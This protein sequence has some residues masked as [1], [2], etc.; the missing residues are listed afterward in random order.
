MRPIK[1]FMTIHNAIREWDDVRYMTFDEYR[2]RLGVLPDITEFRETLSAAD[3][4]P[5]GEPQSLEDMFA[6]YK[7]RN[8]GITIKL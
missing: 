4:E 7:N 6:R 2:R 3:D 1:D 8:G 5:V